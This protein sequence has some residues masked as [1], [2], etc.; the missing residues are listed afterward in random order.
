MNHPYQAR[1]RADLQGQGTNP[2]HE[3]Q[4]EQPRLEQ[5][6]NEPRYRTGQERP[7]DGNHN[8]VTI[9]WTDPD[10][11]SRTTTG[12]RTPAK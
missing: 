11:V 9:R 12:N 5:S 10:H 7:T 2:V 8:S 6:P 4:K 1:Q 3:R